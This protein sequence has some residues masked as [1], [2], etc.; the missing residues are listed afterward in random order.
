MASVHKRKHSRY[1]QCVFRDSRGVQISRSSRLT[2]RREALQLAVGLERL[3]RENARKA[4]TGCHVRAIV[5]DLLR[6]IG[7]APEV[8]SISGWFEFWLSNKVRSKASG[9]AARYKGVWS[10]FQN[11]LGQ[12]AELPLEAL[13]VTDVL[14]FRDSCTHQGISSA[15]TNLSLKTLRSALNAAVA[16]GHLVHNPA[17]AVD[18]LPPDGSVRDKFTHD[19]I[20]I[21][22]QTAESEEWRGLILVGY[23]VGARLG[24]CA[25]LLFEDVDFVNK[26]IRFVPEKQQR[27][28]VPKTMVVPLHPQL[29]EWLAARK[30]TSGPIFPTLSRM[31]TG[32]MTGLSLTFRALMDKAGIECSVKDAVGKGRKVFSLSFHSLRHTFNSD[33]ANANVS[34]E[35]RRKLIGHAS[36]R[37]NDLYTHVELS[38]LHTAIVTLP[39]LHIPPQRVK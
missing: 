24:T 7:D 21:L 32:G 13:S 29:L 5:T 33:L 35:I 38:T 34:Q 12:R 25:K 2:N 1:W 39:P 16:Q 18:L 14:K 10:S 37:V 28:K 36:D 27:A 31:K 17:N 20:E 26:T 6:A 9:T 11:F 4:L 30:R 22:L 8:Y 19:Q 15:S 3:A 23:F